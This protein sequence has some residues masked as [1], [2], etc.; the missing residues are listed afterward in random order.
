MKN[1]KQNPDYLTTSQVI[2][3]VT[4]E[5]IKEDKTSILE[6]SGTYDPMRC[7]QSHSLEEH[8]IIRF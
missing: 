4:L 6:T 8:N 7:D 1:E 5:W 2:F 3:S